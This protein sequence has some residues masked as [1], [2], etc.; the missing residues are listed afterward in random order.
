MHYAGAAVAV[1]ASLVCP[2]RRARAAPGSHAIWPTASRPGRTIPRGSLSPG[3]DAEVQTLAIRYGARIRKS[4]RGG[5]VLEVTGGQL[6]ALSED[7]DVAHLSGDVPVQRMMAVTNEATGASQVWRRAGLAPGLHG[8]RA[9]ASRSS[10]PASRRTGRS[11][12][13]IVAQRGLHRPPRA[14]PRPVR[15]RHARRG[16]HRRPR[17]RRLRGH[18]ARRPHRQPAGA[19]P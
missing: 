10:T 8:P 15:A 13:A 3:T 1:L 14:G 12:G 7:P 17:R 5:A 11:A 4:V 19:R 18:R 9:S 16:H 2:R 6:V